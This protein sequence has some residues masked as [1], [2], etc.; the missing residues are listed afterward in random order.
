MRS[1]TVLQMKIEPDKPR[2]D[3]DPTGDS[4]YSAPAPLSATEEARLIRRAKAKDR[5]A[6]GV[7]YETYSQ[8][9]YHYLWL[10]LPDEHLAEDLMGEVFVRAM[11]GLPRYT[12]RGLPFGAWLFRIAHD[13]LVDYYRQSARRPWADLDENLTSEL[14]NPDALVEIREKAR[15]I[16]EALRKLTDDQRDVVQFRF[17]ED[18]SLEDTARMMNK[19][20]N[21][22]KALQ[23][24][25]LAMLNRLLKDEPGQD[26]YDD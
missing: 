16:S 17:I 5:Q 13:R 1:E 9:I 10:R 22:V 24:R 19:S 18:W 6:F 12:D 7:L 8:A 11:N 15:A 23:H 20:V 2:G 3:G 21:A 4:S 26:N 14:P 25:A